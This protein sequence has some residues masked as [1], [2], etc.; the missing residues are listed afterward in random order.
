[1]GFC[2]SSLS[3]DEL[4]KSQGMAKQKNQYTMSSDFSGARTYMWYAEGLKNY[5]HAA[6]R[7]VCDTISFSCFKKNQRQLTRSMIIKRIVWHCLSFSRHFARPT[8]LVQPTIFVNKCQKWWVWPVVFF[9]LAPTAPQ[10]SLAQES[11]PSAKVVARLATMINQGG[12]AV[13]RGE[14]LLATYNLD[15]PLIPASIAKLA[16]SLAALNK[17]GPDYRFRTEIY[18]DRNDNLYLKG[19][20]DPFLVSEEVAELVKELHQAG[21]TTINSIFIDETAFDLEAEVDGRDGSLNPYDV[22]PAAMVA[23][24]NTINLRVGPQGKVES[25]EP[26]TP[27]LPLMIELGCKLP[28]G[29]QR[30]NVNAKPDGPALLA[31]QLF[32][33]FQQQTG[34]AGAGRYGRRAAPNG[35]SLVLVHRSSHSLSE[36]IQGL[37]EYS[38][39]F[40]ANQ[41]FLTLGAEEFGYPATWAKSRRALADFLGQDPLLAQGIHLEEGSGLSRRNRVTVRAMLRILE[42]F[43]NYASLLPEKKQCL[44]KSG[45]LAGVYSYAGYLPCPNGRDRV[46]IILNQWQNNRDEVLRILR[47]IYDEAVETNQE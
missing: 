36:L 31:G 42:L 16:T 28:I 43:Q 27:L 39:N 2:K 21:V 40:T 37:L 3:L 4:A 34:I 17:L 32:R 46:V 25:A 22:G 29:G 35:A 7:T 14:R 5:Y 12:Y 8:N 9:L 30:I 19:Y 33:F 41:I 15:Q 11:S 18:L 23:N 44:L 24:F 20:G 10:P 45:T 13:T 47:N 1:M 6:D 26:Q 38:N